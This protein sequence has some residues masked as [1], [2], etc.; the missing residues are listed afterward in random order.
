MN[1]SLKVTVSEM[2]SA[3]SLFAWAWLLNRHIFYLTSF[4]QQLISTI[5]TNHKRNMSTVI[6]TS[7]IPPLDALLLIDLCPAN[8]QDAEHAFFTK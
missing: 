6:Y 4:A 8:V 3:L 5:D 2:L 7:R 1:A